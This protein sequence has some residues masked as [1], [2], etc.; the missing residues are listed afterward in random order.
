MTTF[1]G[2]VGGVTPLQGVGVDNATTLSANVTTS[3]ATL[4]SGPTALAG[5]VTM[6]AGASLTQFIGGVDGNFALSVGPAGSAYGVF[7]SMG[8]SVPLQSFTFDGYEAVFNGNVTAIGAVS[9]AGR[10][11]LAA[12]SV[13]TS[14]ANG[15]V[16]FSGTVEGNGSE[17]L[18]V[19]TGGSTVF[20][21]QVSDVTSLA[22]DAGG[23]TTLSGNVTTSGSQAYGD[24]LVLNTSLTLQGESL[25]TNGVT[26]NANDLALN[27]TQVTSLD[28]TFENIEDLTSEGNVELSGSIETSGSQ[29]YN[30]TATL[31]GNTSLS[32][33][34]LSLASG[35]NGGADGGEGST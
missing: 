6:N 23:T 7:G 24:T 5:D 27:F 18:V 22:T 30:G 12:D 26:G 16:R 20:G 25:S 31:V 4:F 28:G 29:T 3:G 13:V 10:T 14:T 2:V 15:T 21:G 17:S 34:S 33:T 19:N 1:G 32:G 35:V 11:I 9:V 8:E